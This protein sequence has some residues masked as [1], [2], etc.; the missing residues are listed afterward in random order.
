MIKIDTFI[1]MDLKNH[2]S[3]NINQLQNEFI[4]IKNKDS[5]QIIEKNLNQSKG[6]FLNGAVIVEIDYV[7]ITSLFDWDDLNL[8]WTGFLTM[9]IDYLNDGFGKTNLSKNNIEWTLE[10]IINKRNNLVVFSS[11]NSMKSR[12]KGVCEE[13]EFINEVVVS[14]HDYLTLREKDTRTQN[15]NE[16]VEKYNQLKQLIKNK[17][18]TDA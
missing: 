17:N 4:N 5:L 15:L 10:K 18:M 6:H 13:N 7:Q 16:M 8:L 11:K 14:A 9:I 1:A 3:E 12:L 2:F